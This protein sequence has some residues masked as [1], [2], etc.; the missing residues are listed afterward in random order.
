M[1]LKISELL[2]R[3]PPYTPYPHTK[4]LLDPISCASYT[5]LP[6]S[7]RSYLENGKI[8]PVRIRLH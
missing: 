5:M 6:P 7:N 3:L 4:D 2:N 8:H 1:R